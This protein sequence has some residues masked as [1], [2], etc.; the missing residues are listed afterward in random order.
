MAS[1][2]SQRKKL[3]DMESTLAFVIGGGLILLIAGYGIAAA[4]GQSVQSSRA[5][6]IMMIVG[7]TLAITG[8]IAWLIVVKPWTKFDDWSVPLYTGHDNHGAHEDDLTQINGI[9]DK[10]AKVLNAIGIHSFE[11]LAKRKPAELDR[12]VRDAGVRVSSKPEAWISQA[13]MILASSTEA[14]HDHAQSSPAAHH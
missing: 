8:T 6:D 12:I 5:L 3:T 14:G 13:Q 11:D 1:T 10:T 9:N 4:Q 7:V 2:D